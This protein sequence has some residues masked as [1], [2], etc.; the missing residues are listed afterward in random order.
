M[1]RTIVKDAKEEISHFGSIQNKICDVHTKRSYQIIYL[2][3][4]GQTT[5]Q[6]SPDRQERPIPVIGSLEWLKI[7][8][9]SCFVH[10]CAIWGHCYFQMETELSRSWTEAS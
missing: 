5:G 6:G 7:V 4:L 10:I 3:R 8:S 9:I 2:Q 1:E